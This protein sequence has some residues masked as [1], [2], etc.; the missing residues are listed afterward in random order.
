M[1]EIQLS[2]S[3]CWSNSEIARSGNLAFNVA[4][5]STQREGI[6]THKSPVLAA[7]LPHAQTVTS[8]PHL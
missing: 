6:I 7:R 5:F 4:S 2:T 8:Q 3:I 1:T